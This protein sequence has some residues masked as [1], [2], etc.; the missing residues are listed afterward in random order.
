MFENENVGLHRDNGL[1]IFRNLS[2]PEIERKRKAIL[3][4]FEECGLS[5]ATKTNLKVVNFL[6]IQLGL[7][8]GTYWPY[9]KPNGNLM[10]VV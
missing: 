7:I 1:W 8:N 5:T 2:G 6:N 4:V 10:Y 3:C 9:R